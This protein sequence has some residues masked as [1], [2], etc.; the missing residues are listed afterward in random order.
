MKKDKRQ[1]TAVGTTRCPL[2]F[3]ANHKNIGPS[4]P[5]V[6]GRDP[7]VPQAEW[8]V[9]YL[10]TTGKNTSRIAEYIANQ[11]K[12]DESGEQLIMSELG[13]FTGASNGLTATGRPYLHV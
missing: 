8:I 12:E 13:P 2:S 7:F 5:D 9:H 6:K 11:L 10:D 1:R 4:W 3:S